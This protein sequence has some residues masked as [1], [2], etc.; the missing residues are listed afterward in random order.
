MVLMA[1]A[2]ITG[3]GAFLPG[4]PVDNDQ[5]AVRFGDGSVR[6]AGLRQRV[7]AANGIR[8]RHY[9]VDVN[10]APSMLNEELATRAVRS[11]LDDR[12]I[13]P[14]TVRM[15]AAA[16]TQGDLLVPG[17]ASMV[18]GTAS[19]RWRL[20]WVP[21]WSAARSR[22]SAARTRP[23]PTSCGGHCRTARARGRSSPN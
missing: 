17:F 4:E 3:V 16:T 21:I 9:A 22:P 12:G 6:S 18:H 7:L 23:M 8:T 20:P 13:E 1:E 14:S 11:A 19:T 2:Y 15:L 5:L 10:G